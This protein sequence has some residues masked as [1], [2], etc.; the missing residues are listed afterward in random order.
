M[1]RG[2]YESDGRWDTN[3][4]SGVGVG[5]DYSCT[6]TIPGRKKVHTC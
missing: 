5:I 2:Y 6:A 1:Y 3:K 4:Q